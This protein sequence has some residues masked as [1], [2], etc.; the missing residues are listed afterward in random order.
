MS[1]YD[2]IAMETVT[3]CFFRHGNGHVFIAVSRAWLR[4]G[5]RGYCAGVVKKNLLIIKISKFIVLTSYVQAGTCVARDQAPE[6]N[7]RVKRFE[8]LPGARMKAT[9]PEDIPLTPPIHDTRFWYHDLIGH[10][11]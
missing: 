3:Q 9:E 6:E 1:S 10:F 11:A 4:E 2:F 7:L 8:S 5:L